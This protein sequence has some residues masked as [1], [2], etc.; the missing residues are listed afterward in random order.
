MPQPYDYSIGGTDPTEAFLKGVQI[1]QQGKQ[2]QAEYL[3]AQAAQAEVQR[4]TDDANRKRTVFTTFLGPGA[5]IAQRNEAM[6]QLPDDVVAIQTFFKG[7]DEGRKGFLLE[8]ARAAYND[9][10]PDPSGNV[11]IQS[12]ID[13]L[14]IRADAAK[15]SGDT[16]LETRIRDLASSIG[17]PGADPRLA[18]GVID[19]QVRAVDPDAADKMTGSGDARALMRGAGIDPYSDQGREIFGNMAFRQGQILLTGVKTPDNDEYTGTLQDYL[20]RYGSGGSIGQP[21]ATPPAPT[22]LP[23]SQRPPR[24][25]DAQLISQGNAAALAGKN[26]EQIFRQ[27]QAWGVNP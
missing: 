14:N 18:Q 6:R 24:M 11:N 2:A 25:T 8:T 21:P 17:T 5:T 12:A 3:R 22:I 4:K 9:L 13:K 15:N 27:L 23:L 7:I 20:A 16:V 1:A 19:L 26:V 10:I